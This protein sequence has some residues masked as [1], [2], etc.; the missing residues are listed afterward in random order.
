MLDETG[1][2]RFLQLLADDYAVDDTA[3]EAAIAAYQA[4]DRRFGLAALGREQ[5]LRALDPT[6]TASATAQKF[7]K[8]RALL[9]G[10]TSWTKEGVEWPAEKPWLAKRLADSDA[11]GVRE[12]L[13]LL[14][15]L[16]RAN[17]RLLIVP[18]HD[19]RIHAKIPD[20]GR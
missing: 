16:Q 18:A 1:K 2:A 17:P 13:V 3:V 7:L 8:L 20:F 12:Q 4:R 14:H 10:D 9:I 5:N 11:A 19:Y 6:Y 15:R